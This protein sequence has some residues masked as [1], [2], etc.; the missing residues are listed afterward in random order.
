W[1]S[2][3]NCPVPKISLD[4]AK[5]ELGD[6]AII[7]LRGNLTEM[8]KNMENKK[9]PTSVHHKNGIEHKD[10][11]KEKPKEKVKEAPK[12]PEPIIPAKYKVDSEKDSNLS[13]DEEDNE[14]SAGSSG[15]NAN[16]NMIIEPPTPM[17]R[18]SRNNSLADQSSSSDAEAPKPRPRT[19]T[20]AYKVPL[21]NT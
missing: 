15:S 13:I 17:P 9:C 4:P 12:E 18:T 8:V 21:F 20:P 16:D 10:K 3:T 14:N 5:R 1:I 2:G 6:A 11:P 7:I 19:K